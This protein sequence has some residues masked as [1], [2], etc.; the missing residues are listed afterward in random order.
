MRR[1]LKKPNFGILRHTARAFR[2]AMGV[3]NR[4]TGLLV[5]MIYTPRHVLREGFSNRCEIISVGIDDCSYYLAKVHGGRLYTN[6]V[7]NISVIS[8]MQLVPSVS[9]Q[10]LNG[11]VLP[12][13]DNHLLDRRLLINRTPTHVNGEVV[14]LLTGG[15]G[16]YNYY[17]W[18][19]DC[20]PRLYI[21]KNFISTDSHTKYCIP[22]DTHPF[23][24]ETLEVLG[25][26][27]TSRI[28]SNEY[29]HLRAT[30]LLATSHP[31]PNP[32]AIP[33]WIVR[34]LRESFL[35]ISSIA[36]KSR[37]VYVSRGD[38]VNARRLLNE[39]SLCKVLESVGFGIFH[40]SEL[41]FQDQVALFSQAKMVVGVHGAGLANLAFASSG[42]VVYEIFSDQ[43]KPNMYER[44]S[45]LV[46]IEY[47]RIIC[48]VSEVE[49]PAQLADFR[50]SDICVMNIL[51]H[52][53]QIVAGDA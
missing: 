4:L 25:I 1:C 49:K 22:E 19:F 36:D 21:V 34:F 44:I 40:L 26:P 12:D 15:G 37:F 31:N 2:I 32:S 18:L 30:L 45:L 14:S 16:N 39:D 46:N 38:S 35:G 29:S 41:T 50:I 23:Q 13:T 7:T 33:A 52:A 9:W 3:A 48:E 47:H 11:K 28:S 24:R 42:A 5:S 8:Q 6:R 51:K 10:Y 43:Y 20:L 27:V 17:H 53:E